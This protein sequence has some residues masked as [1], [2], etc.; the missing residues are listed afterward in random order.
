MAYRNDVEVK[1]LR[2]N[3]EKDVQKIVRY[4]VAGNLCATQVLIDKVD[5]NTR[6]G[7]EVYMELLKTNDQTA[8]ETILHKADVTTEC[9]NDLLRELASKNDSNVNSRIIGICNIRNEACRS[10][11]AYIYGMSDR[12]LRTR[13]SE[14]ANPDN[15]AGRRFIEVHL[16]A[17]DELE[18]GAGTDPSTEDGRDALLSMFENSEMIGFVRAFRNVDPNTESGMR[19]LREINDMRYRSTAS[20]I[21]SKADP[22]NE[23]GRQCIMDVA[24][25]RG[26]SDERYKARAMIEEWA[27]PESE[28]DMELVRRVVEANPDRVEKRRRRYRR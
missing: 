3:N 13:I 26:N 12:F 22:V 21:I 16:R 19:L 6:I 7:R 4:H 9:G 2:P 17:G 18:K 10:L 5:P 11:L 15:Q 27:D 23:Y 20:A 1:N 24:L 28:A 25:G 8:V 14:M